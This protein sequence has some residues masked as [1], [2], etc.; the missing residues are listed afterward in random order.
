MDLLCV[1]ENNISRIKAINMNTEK[2]ST[3][4]SYPKGE[5]R[6]EIGSTSLED[7]L[8]VVLSKIYILFDPNLHSSE[9]IPQIV[10]DVDYNNVHKSKRFETCYMLMDS[11]PIDLLYNGILI[12]P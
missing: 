1:A 2:R 4:I 7:N 3:E 11:R 5:R 8:P 9:F 12:Q 10:K 6:A